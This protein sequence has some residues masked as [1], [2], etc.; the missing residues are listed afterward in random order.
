M[1]DC[2]HSYYIDILNSIEFHPL[3]NVYLASF[4]ALSPSVSSNSQPKFHC[5]EF[6]FTLNM[7]V[8]NHITLILG[9]LYVNGDGLN[10]FHIKKHGKPRY[11]TLGRIINFVTLNYA[12]INLSFVG[13]CLQ[14]SRGRER[15]RRAA[16]AVGHG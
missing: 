3:Q 6:L 11:V 12:V 2:S 15:A 1:K 10:F 8:L 14:T 16:A 4:L 5:C 9:Y 13:L 7:M